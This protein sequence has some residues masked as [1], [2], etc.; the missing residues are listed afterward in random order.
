[1]T[2]SENST[3]PSSPSPRARELEPD[4]D[5]AWIER[6]TEILRAAA[7]GN[8]ESRLVHLG[9][10]PRMRG[11]LDAINDMLDVTDG[12][13]RESGAS[14]Q[15]AKDGRFSRKILLRGFDGDF[16]RAARLINDASTEMRVKH[17]ALATAK[18][19]RT[20][21]ADEFEG[22]VG[23]VVEAVSRAADTVGAHVD[24]LGEQIEQTLARVTSVAAAAEEVSASVGTVATAAEELDAS[25]REI[26]DRTRRSAESAV[27]MGGEARETRTKL[28]DLR[29]ASGAIGGVVGFIRDVAMQTNLLSL[30][31]AIEAA[32]VGE[33]GRGF[34]VVAHEVKNLAGETAKATDRIEAQVR[35]LELTIGAVIEQ[36]EQVATNVESYEQLMMDIEVAV[37]EQED[38][39]REISVNATQVA[40]ASRQVA[41]NMSAVKR[42]SEA[43]QASG[44]TLQVVA[45]ALGGEVRSLDANAR[46]FIT[47]VRA[48]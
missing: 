36:V 27:A 3:P 47:R 40:D 13:V 21:M 41:S 31:A 44:G 7:Q 30:N 10:S 43:A 46:R 12:F 2:R 8:F 4:G 18:R 9:G 6:A 34:A 19:S 1:M 20:E 16:A 35:S 14:L 24:A 39:T 33:A 26:K 29:E 15:A 11:L 38:A 28:D 32:R 25:A 48:G 37:S 17:E 42:N 5:A 45:S 22:Q 23:G